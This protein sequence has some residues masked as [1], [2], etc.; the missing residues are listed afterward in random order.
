MLRFIDPQDTENQCADTFQE[1][2]IIEE[3]NFRGKEDF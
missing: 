3:N 1:W 2:Y